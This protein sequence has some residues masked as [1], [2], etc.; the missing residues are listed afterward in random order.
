MTLSHS[1][2]IYTSCS[3]PNFNFVKNL[4]VAGL[5]L[6]ATKSQPQLVTGL[7]EAFLG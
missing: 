3:T 7:E 4:S 2:A 5:K 6:I 1:P